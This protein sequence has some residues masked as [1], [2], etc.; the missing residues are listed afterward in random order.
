MK[1]D[2]E[3]VRQSLPFS[4]KEVE[5]LAQKLVEVP[6]LSG[7]ERALL[8]AV[9]SAAGDH[10]TVPGKP[11]ELTSK[12]LAEQIL[13]VFVPDVNKEYLITSRIGTDPVIHPPR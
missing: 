8:L 4:R 12:N 11:P 3:F 10:V 7:P 6:H 9:F 2:L 13:R 5:D 1:E